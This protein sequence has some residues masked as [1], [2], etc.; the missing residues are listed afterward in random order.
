VFNIIIV[1]VCIYSTLPNATIHIAAVDLQLIR[2][3]DTALL[4]LVLLHIAS[5]ELAC[6]RDDN[7]IAARKQ[8]LYALLLQEVPSIFAVLNGQ[9]HMMPVLSKLVR[10]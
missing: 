6:P 2:C 4:G 8:E 9:F 10:A 7:I 3:E 1:I 5:E